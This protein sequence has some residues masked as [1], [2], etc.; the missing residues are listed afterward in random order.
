METSKT[1]ER[2]NLAFSKSNKTQADLARDT[3]LGRPA[4][5]QYLKGKVIPKQDKIYLLAEALNVSPAWLMGVNNDLTDFNG[6][7][8]T[9]KSKEEI[10]AYKLK[11]YLN[12]SASSKEIIAQVCDVKIDEVNKWLNGIKIPNI[13]I[14][15]KLTSYFKCYKS[16]LTELV[17]RSSLSTSGIKVPVLGRVVAGIPIEAIEEI[18]DYEE[19]SESMART[20]DFFALQVKGD[21][22]EP[23]MSEGDVVI[24]RKQEIAQTGDVAIVLVN[25]DEATVKK[26]RIMDSGIMLIPFN[27]KY[28][29]WI[30]TAE[31]IERLPV[32]IIGKVVECR[33]KY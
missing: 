23:K 12:M 13:T 3:N 22:M 15:Q 18:L 26:I 19:I 29:P 11:H 6:N 25:G 17:G 31:D 7:P 24:V 21:S 30:Y 2:L 33:Q 10:F 32:K 8:K 5:S 16:D 9:F 14:L 20:G 4:I 27:T 1:T 28:D